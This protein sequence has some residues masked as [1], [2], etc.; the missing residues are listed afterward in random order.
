MSQQQETFLLCNGD[1]VQLGLVNFPGDG[2]LLSARRASKPVRFG[3]TLYIKKRSNDDR[4]VGKFLQLILL[5]GAGGLRG[6]LFHVSVVYFHH[7]I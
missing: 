3:S 5:D 6:L 4:Y 2:R 7:R 1:D